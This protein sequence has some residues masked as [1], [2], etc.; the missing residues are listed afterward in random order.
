VNRA[1]QRDR[2]RIGRGQ[3]TWLRHRH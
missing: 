1:R 2:D 3:N